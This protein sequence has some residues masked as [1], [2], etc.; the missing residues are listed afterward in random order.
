VASDWST[1]EAPALRA[2]CVSLHSRLAAATGDHAAAREMLEQAPDDMP[3]PLALARLRLSAG[4]PDEALGLL[5]V[6][7]HDDAIDKIERAVL[8]AVA[9][10]TLGNTEESRAATGQALA[11]GEAESI[12]RPLLDAGPSLRELLTDHLRHS[13]AHRWFASDLLSALNGHEDGGSAPAELLEPLTAREADV[14]RYLP[15]MMSN[16]DIA[17]ELFVSV[18]TIKSHVKSI[19]RKLD[20][21][22]RR[23]AVGR[24]RQLHLL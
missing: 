6:D 24:A 10:R 23:D 5:A 15:T 20:A 16:A 22:Q 17:A 7:G 1:V 4:E 12:R 19:Y 11:L 21:T 2:M 9:H 3:A 18:N 14:L 8:S 13:T